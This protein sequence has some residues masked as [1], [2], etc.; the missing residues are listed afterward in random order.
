MIATM[1][2]FPPIFCISLARATERRANM[3]K[4]LDT[5]GMP[6]QFVNAVDGKDLDLSEYKDRFRP[7]EFR[8]IRGR[9]IVPGEIGCFLSHYR[10]WEAMVDAKTESALI[11]EDDA[12]WDEDL[13]DVVIDVINADWHWDVVLLSPPKRYLV[14][15]VLSEVGKKKR[16]LV[17]YKERAKTTAGYLIRLPG[18]EKLCRYCWDIRAPIDWLMPMWWR[19]QLAF[20]CVDPAPITQNDE[21][22]MIKDSRLL[23]QRA[24]FT[25][26]I[27]GAL[28][29]EWD[30]QYH[31]FYRWRHPPVRLTPGNKQN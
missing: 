18:A 27:L 24:N 14:D 29:R 12:E 8:R 19:N 11:V 6:Y 26:R 17:R 30:K 3:R 31:R 16:R 10:L 1:K 5:L 7:D 22:S 9:E 13:V 2:K 21:I 28:D 25:E 15:S 20:Y 4:R 23:R